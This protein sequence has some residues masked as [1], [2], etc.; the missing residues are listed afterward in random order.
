MSA[1]IGDLKTAGSGIVS[2]SLSP[3]AEAME[4]VGLVAILKT[5]L[6]AGKSLFNFTVYTCGLGL[7]RR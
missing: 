5:F 3:S 2:F 7:D 4:T 1:R 6:N